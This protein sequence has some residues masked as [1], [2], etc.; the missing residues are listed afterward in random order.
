MLVRFDRQ[1]DAEPR[2]APVRGGHVDAAL[3]RVHDL[4]DDGEAEPGALRLGREK[5]VEDLLGDLRRHARPVVGDVD[6]HGRHRL[7]AVGQQRAVGG[8]VR[9]PRRDLD[10]AAAFERLVGVDQ[11]VGRTPA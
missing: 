2:A 8:G 3:V 1:R 9:E 7:V 5:R 4:A 6:D 11:Q 10:A